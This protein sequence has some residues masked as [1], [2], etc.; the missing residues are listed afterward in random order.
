MLRLVIPIKVTRRFIRSK[1]WPRLI[2]PAAWRS[3]L[4]PPAPCPACAKFLKSNTLAAG[5]LH[6]LAFHLHHLVIAQPGKSTG[7]KLLWLPQ[8]LAN[9][10]NENQPRLLTARAFFVAQHRR[11][12]ES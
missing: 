2:T 11:F 9:V 3:A 5:A 4:S 1:P 10:P 7:I 6:L 12:R 8:R